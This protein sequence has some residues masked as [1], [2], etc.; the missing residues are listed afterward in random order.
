[1]KFFY[2]RQMKTI[3][4]HIYLLFILLL[5]TNCEENI[6][7]DTEVYFNDFELNDLNNISGG[8]FTSFNE[9]QVIGNFNNDG[10]TLTLNDLPDHDY[11]I[12]EMDLYIHDSWDGNKNELNPPGSDQDKWILELDSGQ[13]NKASDDTF[14]ETTFSNGPCISYQCLTQSYPNIY[15]FINDPKTGSARV[16]LPGLCHLA[17]DPWGTTLY[18]FEKWFRHTK[19]EVNISFYDR[20]LQ[21]NSPNPKC[22]ESWS[23]DNL[24]IRIATIE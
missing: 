21:T 13:F 10:F 6:S 3:S 12:V 22:D 4:H 1:M 9:S 2:Y 7:K 8:N 16:P 24:R 11:L 17:D 19:T 5:T 14:Y 18:R 23:V 15:P 20:L